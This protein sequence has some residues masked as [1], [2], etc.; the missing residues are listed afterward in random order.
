MTDFQTAPPAYITTVPHVREVILEGTA[1]YA[2][3]Q[4]KL[5]PEGLTPLRDDGQA[6]LLVSATRLR[7]MGLRFNELS[8]SV[9]LCQHDDCAAPDALYLLHAFNSLPL[10]AWTERT[11][12]RTPYFPAAFQFQHELPA[13]F[14]VSVGEQRLLRADMAPRTTP[15][16]PDVELWEGPI[17]LPP[18]DA[19]ARRD[20]FFASLGGETQVFPFHKADVFDVSPQPDVPVLQWLADSHFAGRAWRLRTG[21]THAK[22]ATVRWK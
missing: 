14:S 7:W 9:A 10:L 22:S 15:A 18:R 20:H 11:F 3:W 5:T 16:I 13:H 4:A 19:S 12:F 8:I 6:V 17:Y 1:D 21:A 2:F